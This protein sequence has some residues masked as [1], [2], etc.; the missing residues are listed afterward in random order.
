MFTSQYPWAPP[1]IVAVFLL[2]GLFLRRRALAAR[3]TQATRAEGFTTREWKRARIQ[4][5][6]TFGCVLL[7]ILI[8]VMQTY[9]PSS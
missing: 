2:F 7:L 8:W 3:A 9:F 6:M 5:L 1:A 4:F